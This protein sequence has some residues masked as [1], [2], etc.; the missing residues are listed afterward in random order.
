MDDSASSCADLALLESLN[1]HER[2]ILALFAEHR[3]NQEIA[4]TLFLSLNTVKWYARQ[5][6]GKLGVANRREA[7]VRAGQLGL[8]EGSEPT[9]SAVPHNLPVHLT[10]FI[11]RQAEMAA[12]RQM[13]RD[14]GCRLLTITGPGGMGKTRLA[15]AAAD[16]F[17]QDTDAPFA[18]GVFLVALADLDA[19]DH[20]ATA[21]AHAVGLHFL[22]S[23][24]APA[25]QL[26]N[27]LRRKRLLLVLDN[28]EH[29]LGGASLRFVSDVLAAAPGIKMLVTS[30][31]RLNLQ[32]EQGFPLYGL[33]LGLTIPNGEPMDGH[34]DSI[35]LFADAARRADP[36]FTLNTAML[37]PVISMCCL[38]EGMPLAI[39][40]AAAW[41]AALAPADILAEIRNGL[42]FLASDAA[43]VPARHR[44]LPAVFDTSWQLLDRAEREA[45]RGLSVFRGG[46]TCDA[47]RAVTGVS[48]QVLL[49]LVRK[50][51][52]QRDAAGRYRM[53]ALLQQYAVG[54]LAQDTALQQT[55]RTRHSLYF[56]RWLA[57]GKADLLG[58]GHVARM[59]AI[60]A[61]AE[62]VH[63]ACLWA[64]EYGHFAELDRAIESLGL[65]YRRETSYLAGDRLLDQLARD[66]TGVTDTNALYA[67]ARILTWRCYFSSMLDDHNTT[68]LAD[69]AL[70]L[71]RSPSLAGRDTRDLQARVY[72]GL[73]SATWVYT[74]NAVEAET[75]FCRSLGLFEQLD[76]Q[77]GMALASLSFGRFLRTLKRFAEAEAAFRRTIQLLESAGSQSGYSDALGALGTLAYLD[78]RFD[79]A[80]RLLTESL[81]MAAPDDHDAEAT[82]LFWLARTYHEGGKLHKAALTMARC[83]SW[84]RKQGMPIF[85][86]RAAV[87]GAMICRDAGSYEKA[88]QLAAEALLQSQDNGYEL[89]E[90][91]ALAVLGSIACLEGDPHAALDYLRKSMALQP[92]AGTVL[93]HTGRL[94]WSS[95][96]LRALGKSDQAWQ[97]AWLQL[98]RSLGARCYLALLMALAGLALLLADD[99]KTEQAVALHA[100]L[101]QHPYTAHAHWFSEIITPGIAAAAAALSAEQR[102]AAEERGQ[103]QDMWQVAAQLA[104]DVT[105][106]TWQDRPTPNES[107]KVARTP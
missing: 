90:G 82:A 19:P 44:S 63:A 27:Y 47:A 99:G 76:D 60:S 92:A 62:N 11:G 94:T 42:D 96:V 23:S 38:V 51:W 14:P 88:R 22:S 40:L 75:H 72:L 20:I 10:P 7:V 58:L 69:Q 93:V 102:S 55:V 33:D 26:A 65:Y 105:R 89:W 81:S 2:Q 13:L 64:A 77:I 21:I 32:G 30:R 59:K 107:G 37:A 54:R 9:G 15:L 25:M 31:V 103:M 74:A 34:S 106:Q 104:E 8:L 5:I 79:E 66:L 17:V 41:T 16:Q 73:G 43:N 91:S 35:K 46:F 83:L 50:S 97:H 70:A 101:L 68:L 71:L 57:E 48:L 3:G 61:D 45:I 56:C 86:A 100:L 24:K 84:R 4:D 49:G 29:L 18:D 6:Y 52:L 53:H 36:A 12:I 28:F 98:D 1:E 85:V 67:L 78:A 80:E 39:E 95:L 87:H